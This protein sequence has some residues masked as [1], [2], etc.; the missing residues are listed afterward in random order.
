[1]NILM[2]ILYPPEHQIPVTHPMTGNYSD[3]VP[4]DN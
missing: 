2:Q 1:M 4:L 3:S